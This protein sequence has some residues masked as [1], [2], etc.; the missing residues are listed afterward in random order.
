MRH[1]RRAVYTL[2]LA[3]A[4]LL[5]HAAQKPS[6][7]DGSGP[8]PATVMEDPDAGNRRQV[9]LSHGVNPYAAD[10]IAFLNDGFR[11]DDLPKGLP[12]DPTMKTQVLNAAIVELGLTGAEE[13]VPILT[14]IA[15]RDLPTGARAIVRRDFE[16]LPVDTIDTQVKTVERALSLNAI[17]ALGFIGNRD[18]A[19]VI[20]EMMRTEP[21]T[22]FVTK[23]AISLG[24]MGMNDGIPAVVLLASD[25][26]SDD[27]VAAFETVYILTGR[28]YG[29]SIYTPMARRRE[30]IAQLKQWLEQGGASEP[31]GRLDVM[32]RMQNPPRSEAPLDT[33]S[34]RGLLRASVDIGDYDKRY[35]AR[36][37][38]TASAPQRFDELK[39]IVQD[40][41][42]DLDIRRAAMQWLS[43]S[44]PKKAK[45]IIDR[46]RKDENEVI[47]AFAVSLEKDIEDAIAYEKRKGLR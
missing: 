12:K 44:N 6:T 28:N 22:A 35:A 38:L 41:R 32:R 46:Q 5:L 37:T 9:L 3:L 47:A 25:P 8:W 34:L 40:T 43:I 31:I 45:S 39:L 4:P 33:A 2:L 42:E 26:A 27:S 16:S 36:E 1:A 14:R 19:P 18:A 29:Y 13:A 15:R 24:Q 10:L 21:A 30:L 17:T 11:V 20:L 23:G 7:T